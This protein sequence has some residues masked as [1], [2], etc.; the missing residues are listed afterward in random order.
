MMDR[1]GEN[2]GIEIDKI[3]A[4]GCQLEEY[5]GRALDSFVVAA[6]VKR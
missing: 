4:A 5:L 6:A 3:T 2:T 1:M